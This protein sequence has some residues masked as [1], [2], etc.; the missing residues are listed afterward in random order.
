M[1]AAFRVKHLGWGQSEIKASLHG[2]AIEESK[3]SAT[4]D[5]SRHQ[6]PSARPPY[7]LVGGASNEDMST[8]WQARGSWL[9]AR[10]RLGKP[11]LLASRG[12]DV[13]AGGGWTGADQ[14]G[15]QGWR[16]TERFSRRS[17]AG[18]GACAARCVLLARGISTIFLWRPPLRLLNLAGERKYVLARQS[19]S[20]LTVL[21]APCP[22]RLQVGP[23]MAEQEAPRSVTPNLLSIPVRSTA[24]SVTTNPEVPCTTSLAY[25]R[26]GDKSYL[27]CLE[28]DEPPATTT[29]RS[30]A[31]HNYEDDGCHRFGDPPELTGSLYMGEQGLRVCRLHKSDEDGWPPSRILPVT[32]TLAHDSVLGGK[33]QAGLTSAHRNFLR[34]SPSP[35]DQER[36]ILY[37]FK[38]GAAS[39]DKVLDCCETGKDRALW[40]HKIV[41]AAA[42]LETPTAA[43]T[44][45]L[46][47]LVA[48]APTI[49]DWSPLQYEEYDYIFQHDEP[50]GAPLSQTATVL[51]I[52]V[53]EGGEKYAAVRACRIRGANL[54]CGDSEIR[55]AIQAARAPAAAAAG[56]PAPGARTYYVGDSER[57]LDDTMWRGDWGWGWGVP[58]QGVIL[59][60][61]EAPQAVAAA[62]D[63]VP[64]P[65]D[66]AAFHAWYMSLGMVVR[67]QIQ[68]N[69]MRESR[70]RE[71]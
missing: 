54:A 5:R 7:Q 26:A 3:Q 28:D 62:P 51:V 70:R 49:S 40:V 56:G 42:D 43:T 33:V 22:R 66:A 35:N 10:A 14:R 68:E 8:L 12:L 17:P 32:L 11:A 19:V 69:I 47:A 61:G 53:V 65:Q 1:S 30:Q 34:L 9:N 39:L 45:V 15:R 27:F 41:G 52:V 25:R 24:A 60:G 31:H 18:L 55:D 29:G 46:N 21:L 57:L 23:P 4:R 36:V 67:L 6:E 48:S 2:R 59:A 71:V 20:M 38:G 44:A 16:Q 64:E 13:V 37:I 50:V 58:V 63:A